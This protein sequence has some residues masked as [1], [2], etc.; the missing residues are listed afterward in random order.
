MYNQKQVALSNHWSF[1]KKASGFPWLQ[2]SD[3]VLFFSWCI[4][5]VFSLKLQ[6]SGESI[7][8]DE[9][10]PPPLLREVIWLTFSLLHVLLTSSICM[11]CLASIQ[12]KQ[13]TGTERWST[14]A[15]STL[16]CEKSPPPPPLKNKFSLQAGKWLD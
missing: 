4:C 9:K 11:C 3:L 15:P 2:E 13:Y 16:Q 1:F 14:Q 8:Q 6:A 7:P 10:A 5:Y 12:V